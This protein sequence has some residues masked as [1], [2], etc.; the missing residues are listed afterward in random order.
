M[1]KKEEGGIE[2]QNNTLHPL[3]K[4]IPFQRGEN[5]NNNIN[6]NKNKEEEEF[7][8]DNNNNNNNNNSNKKKSNNS[9]P[10]HFYYNQITGRVALKKFAPEIPPT[11]GI[12]AEEMG[13][14][15]N[16]HIG[17]FGIF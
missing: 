7:E 1:I 2:D 4:S 17:H 6:K 3:F 13:N 16:P 11:G 12:L 8:D 9:E 15:T 14:N 10:S 5:N